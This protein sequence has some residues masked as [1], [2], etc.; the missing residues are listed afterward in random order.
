MKGFGEQNKSKKK[1]NQKIQPSREQIINQAIQFHLK[2]NILEAI[3]C[4]QYC[5][6]KG[7]NDH[8]VFSNYAGILQGFGKLQEAELS[9]RKAIELKPN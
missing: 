4:Y 2:G 9:F 7:F 3:K 5:I 1:S 6:N 8:R